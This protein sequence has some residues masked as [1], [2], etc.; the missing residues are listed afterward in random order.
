MITLST[1][2]KHQRD[3][4]V[5]VFC[6]AQIDSDLTR[7]EFK[8]SADDDVTSLITPRAEPFL[9][10]LLIPAMERGEDIY[11]DA[12]LDAGL[13]H[14]INK[15]VISALCEKLPNL[16]P[17]VV[18]CAHTH[19]AVERS[20]QNRGGMTGMSCGVDSLRTLMVY[21]E[22][23]NNVP[24]RYRLK[25]LSVFD[26]GAFYDSARQFPH[27]LSKAQEVASISN[28]RAIG[29][30]SNIARFYQTSFPLSCTFRHAAC[31]YSLCDIASAYLVSS[32]YPWWLVGVDH[33]TPT[34]MEA[35][36]PVLLPMISSEDL[37][38]ISSCADEAR[39]QKIEEIIRYSPNLAQIDVCT[40]PTDKRDFKLNCGTC[41]KCSDFIIQAEYMGM[42]EGIEPY[43]DM[44]AYERRKFRIFQR[45]FTGKMIY[46]RTFPNHPRDDRRERG[47]KSPFGAIQ[48]GILL[49]KFFV[50]LDVLRVKRI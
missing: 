14:R 12:T 19:E 44:A 34:A 30:H 33:R 24:E 41:R 40:R 50:L 15:Y 35:C 48:T 36:D 29:V 20:S 18:T 17:I 11:V 28:C 5:E 27:A 21:G 9:I 23:A 43:F 16:T 42:R 38:L 3:D 13:L 10:G 46:R 22:H 32:A 45:N 6:T 25:Y 7:V 1:F 49:G 37:E 2:G 39:P 47:V 31:A 26:V 4:G 8:I